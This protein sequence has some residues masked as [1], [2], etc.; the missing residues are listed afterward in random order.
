M[1][2]YE[3]K[4]KTSISRRG[5]KDLRRIL[6]QAIIGM[7]R[8]NKAFKKLYT[9]YTTRNKNQLTGKQTIIALCRKLL[10]IIH[11]IILK[12][13]DYDENKMM[14]SIRYPEEFLKVAV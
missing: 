2:V 6:Y 3:I 4:G 12:D 11:T 1:I 8:T 5:I 9:Y 14:K 10:R 7:I 13:I